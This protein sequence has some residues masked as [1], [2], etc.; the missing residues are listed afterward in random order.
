MERVSSTG[1][2]VTP[3]RRLPPAPPRKSTDDKEG[4]Q[5]SPMRSTM[6]WISGGICA[7]TGVSVSSSTYQQACSPVVEVISSRSP[8]QATSAFQP[9][10][11]ASGSAM[12]VPPQPVPGLAT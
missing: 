10:M 6:R 8:G 5:F 4:S 12:S 1:F 7:C 9:S 2:S 11:M 3:A